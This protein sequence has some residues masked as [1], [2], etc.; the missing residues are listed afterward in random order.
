MNILKLLSTNSEIKIPRN[1]C[2]KSDWQTVLFEINHGVNK[3]RKKLE[4][5]RGS[6][7]PGLPL[8]ALYMT[9]GFLILIMGPS[10]VFM[11]MEGDK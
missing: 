2:L 3:I 10:K 4:K 8:F 9:A 11:T 5:Y 6:H 7:I 1:I